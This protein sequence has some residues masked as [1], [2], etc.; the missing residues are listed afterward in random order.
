MID[1]IVDPCKPSTIVFK[2]WEDDLLRASI[3]KTLDKKEIKFVAR[4]ILKALKA[5]HEGNYVLY[6]LVVGH[7]LELLID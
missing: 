4:R 5:L 3:K 1:E 2:H 7:L 6:T